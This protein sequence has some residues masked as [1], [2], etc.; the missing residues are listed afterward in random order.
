VNDNAIG[1]I[2]IIVN[3]GK[4]DTFDRIGLDLIFKKTITLNE[5]LC[6]VFFH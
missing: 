1:H 6:G 2:Q 3:I 5:L 4:S